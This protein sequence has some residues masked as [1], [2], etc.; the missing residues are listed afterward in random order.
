METLEKAI[1]MLT[2]AEESNPEL[3]AE[4]YHTLASY[5]EKLGKIQGQ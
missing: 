2:K 3:L 5:Q 1:N 4:F